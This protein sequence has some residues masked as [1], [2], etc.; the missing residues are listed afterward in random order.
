[1]KRLPNN[2]D[3]LEKVYSNVRRELGR[4]PNDDMEQID[5]NMIIWIIFMSAT[6][7]AAVHLGKDYQENLRITKNTDYDKNKH[8]S[9]ISRKLILDPKQE[10]FG[11]STI[12][13]DAIP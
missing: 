2:V 3:D 7:K 4:P 11:L 8:L 1:M 6:M 13:W 9:H 5:V 12:D 10:L